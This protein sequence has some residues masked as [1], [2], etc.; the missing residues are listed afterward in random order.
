MAYVRAKRIHRN[1][2]T[3][4]Y[5][6][7]VRGYREDGTVKQEVLAHLG[8]HETPEAALAYWQQRAKWHRDQARNYQHAA[9]YIREGRAASPYYGA[10]RIKR[11]VPRYGTAL[12][13]HPPDYGLMAPKRW[14]F[15]PGTAEE[16]ELQAQEDIAKAERWE[17]RAERLRSVL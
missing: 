10:R 8:P 17:A 3:Y 12:D 1:D 4:T 2:K 6:Q 5:Y 15:S 7:V 11:L 14:F 9:Q 13:S 16:V